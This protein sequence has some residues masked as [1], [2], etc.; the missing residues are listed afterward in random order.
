[1]RSA[2]LAHPRHARAE[3]LGPDGA[4]PVLVVAEDDVGVHAV[5]EERDQTAC[6]RV[7]RRLVVVVRA[8]AAGTGTARSGGC[9][10]APPDRRGQWCTGRRPRPAAP[11][12][13][14]PRA[15]RGAAPPPRAASTAARPP[16]RPPAGRRLGRPLTGRGTARRR[17]DRPRR[18]QMLGEP[19]HRLGRACVE[20]ADR[21]A[22]LAL[23]D[24]PEAVGHGRGPGVEPLGRR[25]RVEGVVQLARAAGAR[26]SGRA[27]PPRGARRGRTA[28]TSPR[29]RSRSCPRAPARWAG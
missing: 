18:G 22:P 21:A 6:P 26:R 3:A 24:E 1:M 5:V 2:R 29:T 11:R 17:A 27:G 25:A 10:A 7:E 13:S 4:R 16:A 23:H 19:R 28:A 12:T 9:R 14:R 20:R 8:A 15:T